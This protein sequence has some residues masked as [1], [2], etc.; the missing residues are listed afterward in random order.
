MC[1]CVCVCVCV[2]FASMYIRKCCSVGLL[3]PV[4]CVTVLVEVVDGVLLVGNDVATLVG[5]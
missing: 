3:I 1:V 2:C 4:A 5:V